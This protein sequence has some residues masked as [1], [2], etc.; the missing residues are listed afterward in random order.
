M[1]KSILLAIFFAIMCFSVG[2]AQKTGVIKLKTDKNKFEVQFLKNNEFTISNS[3]SEVLLKSE[4]TKKGEFI[5][6]YGSNLVKTFNKGMPDIPVISKLI[7]VPQN[8]K[9]KITVVSY[10]EEIID[11]GKKGINKKIM[12]SQPSLRKD[13]N[14]SDVPFYYNEKIYKTDAFYSQGK[15]ADYKD[16]GQMRDSHIGHIQI[17]PFAY[18]PVKNLLKVYNNIK[19]KIEFINADWSKTEQIKKEYTSP[20]FSGANT[21]AVI[22]SKMFNLSSKALVQSTPVTY[23][24]VADPSFHD[25]LQAF[26]TWKKLKGFDVIEAYTDNPDVGSTVSSIKSYLQNLYNN[27]AQGHNAPSF[28]LIVGD[29]DKIP[30]AQHTEVAD[31]PY[32]DLDYAE[33][34]GDYLPEVNFGRWSADN[35]TQVTDIANKTIRYEKYEMADPSYLGQTFLIA[36]DDEGHEDTYGGGAIYYADRYYTNSAHGIYSHTFLQSTIETWGG[37]TQGNAQAHDSI[38][39]DINNGVALANY[40]AHCSPDG[41]FSPSFTQNDLNNYITNTDKFGLWIGNCCQSNKF[42]ENEAFAELAIRKPNAGVIGYI[43]GSQYTYWDEDYWW[44]VGVGSIVAQPTYESTT[45]GSYDGVFHDQANETNDISKW[46]PTNYQMILA[47]NLAV[48]AST[49]GLKPYYWVIYQLAGDPSVSSYIGVPEAMT[50]TPS[51]ATLMMGMTSLNVSSAP[52]S[53]VALSQNGTLIATALSDATGNASLSFASN[54]LFVGNADLV[55]TCQN[56]QPYIGTVKVNPADEPYVV[57][58]SYTTSASP[59]YGQ[60]ITLNVTLENVAVSGSGYDAGNVNAVISTSDS[61]VTITDSTE[62]YGTIIAGEKILID[63]AF[64]ITIADNVPD[65]HIISFDM[66]ITADDGYSWDATINVIANAPLLEIG[67]LVI[68]DI[69]G[70]NN[71]IL[72]PGENADIVIQTTNKGHADIANTAGTL[73]YSGS[74]LTINSASTLPYNLSVNETQLFAFNVTVSNSAQENTPITVQYS[75]SGGNSSQYTNNKDFDLILAYAEY[76]ES[77]AT[78]SSDSRIENVIFGQNVLNSEIS[79]NTTSDGC[80]TYSDF[81]DLTANVV[82]GEKD[83]LIFTIGTCS[84]NYTKAAKVFIDWNGDY[85]FDDI[86]EEVFVSNTSS[87]SFTDTVEIIIPDN[88]KIGNVRMRIVCEETSD[89]SSIS[90]CGTYSW[91]ETEDYTLNI[92]LPVTQGGF[93]SVENSQICIGDNTGNITLSNNFGTVTDW[94]KKLES[95]TW[96]SIG[97]TGNIYS[98]IPAEPGIWYYRAVIDNGIAYSDSIFITVNALSTGGNTGNDTTICEG[99]YIN[100]NLSNQLGTITN[101]ER[102]LNGGSWE[103]I[104]NTQ[105]NLSEKPSE[106]GTWLYRAHVKNGTCNSYSDTTSVIVNPSAVSGII[107]VTNAD[108]CTGSQVT[109]TANQY[110]G[111]IQWQSSLNGT[112]WTDITGANSDSYTTDIL[113]ETTYFRTLVSL[114][115]CNDSISNPEKIKVFLNPVADFYYDTDNQK[116]TFTNTSENATNYLWNFGD[117]NTSA[118]ENPVYIYNESGTYIVML[119]AYSEVCDNNQITKDINVNYVGIPKTKSFISIAPNPNNG[120][121]TVRTKGLNTSN[122]EIRIYSVSGRLIYQNRINS[123]VFEIDLSNQA[124]GIYFVKITSEKQSLNSKLIIQ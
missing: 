122:S 12:P 115:T 89:A 75:V 30:A 92:A 94:E 5:N 78:S 71:N 120:L 80:S 19:L 29:I 60:S 41:W 44:G 123:D 83:S 82:Q 39:T 61:Y 13:I 67:S 118:Q 65:Q 66:A 96:T 105:T 45:E 43:G 6:L 73:L 27:P 38:I 100:L 117:G 87:S 57:L 52:Y 81:S 62:T 70:N 20:F 90:T 3:I 102:Q 7:E 34:T 22:N 95:G 50:V 1:K 91:G 68:N 101:W 107:D 103:Y 35:A 121:F 11:L 64:A 77:R 119:T 40:T 46:F 9:V 72:D 31:S 49:S 47:G 21:S 86:N 113:S 37:N 114:G 4:N 26:I 59:D 58:N 106:D 55:V 79:N 2:F 51:P 15:I 111:N 54:A 124:K 74:D 32:S 53:Y 112:D 98:E 10:N 25:A 88:T 24:I 69:T 17:M 85:D 14:S 104:L 63:N 56:K 48:E 99:S 18:N 42:D 110:D 28:I 8:A 97:Y 116:I 36:G 84:G 109:L 23:V 76:C 108:I 16:A 33:Y 93:L